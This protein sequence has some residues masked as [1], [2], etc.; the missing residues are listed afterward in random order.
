[1]EINDLIFK[2]LIKRGY[3][4]EGNTRVWNIAD[5]K[6]RY[7]TPEQAQAYLDLEGSNEYRK[8][9]GT[10]FELIENNMKEIIKELGNGSFN[11][12][13]LGC[14]DGNK[15]AHII[16]HLRKKSKIRYCP[17]DISGYMVHK[18]VETVSKMN[19][20]EIIDTQWNIS[21]F[22]NLEN[23]TSLLIRGNYKKNLFL[24][25]GSTL[26][27]FEINDILYQIRSSMRTDDV[28]VIVSGIESKKW[29]AWVRDLAAGKKP[30]NNEFFI[31]LPLQLG[32]GETNIEFGARLRHS[33]VEY[34]YT[35]KQDKLIEFQQRKVQFYAGDQIVVAVAYKHNKETTRSILNTYFDKVTIRLSKDKSKFLA[36]CKK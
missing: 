4:L 12:V 11:I 15:A 3:A 2:E 31:H 33:R 8:L 30:K 5:S 10:E 20:G 29:E 16:E 35:I 34:Y 32:L 18:A 27:N 21:D 13:D 7:L 26:G 36:I 22:E 23:I 24:L 28:L 17:I 1:M 14:G 9:V 19:I 25:L 6:L